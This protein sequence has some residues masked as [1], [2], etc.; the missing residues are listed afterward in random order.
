MSSRQRLY[1]RGRERRDA[2][3]ELVE[4]AL[5]SSSSEP[6]GVNDTRAGRQRRQRAGQ[7]GVAHDRHAHLGVALEHAA[8][9]RHDDAQI[10]ACAREPAQPMTTRSRACARGAAAA[11]RPRAGWGRPRGAG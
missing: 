3:V 9:R 5:R 8:Q 2:D 1:S 11:A 10:V 6:A 7:H 4:E